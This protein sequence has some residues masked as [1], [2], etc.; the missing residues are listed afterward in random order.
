MKDIEITV[1]QVWRYRPTGTFERVH[2]IE[3]G[4]STEGLTIFTTIM[5]DGYKSTIPWRKSSFLIEYE[6]VPA[7]NT[8]LWKVL[9]G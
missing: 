5:E 2:R 4:H 1:G 8:P 7:Y 6:I 3:G 9:N